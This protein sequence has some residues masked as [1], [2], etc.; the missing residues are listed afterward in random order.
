MAC[1]KQG[2]AITAVPCDVTD[3]VHSISTGRRPSGI[4]KK[5]YQRA[6]ELYSVR[7]REPGRHL[8]DRLRAEIEVLSA[9][10]SAVGSEISRAR[11]SEQY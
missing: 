9:Q 8:E 3:V 10:V 1:E 2:K 7:S 5:I 11:R 4:E 6:H